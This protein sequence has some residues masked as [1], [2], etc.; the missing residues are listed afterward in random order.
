MSCSNGKWIPFLFMSLV[1]IFDASES[2]IC[3]CFYEP[4]VSGAVGCEIFLT[5]SWQGFESWK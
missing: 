5:T 4:L 3:N 1:R 2:F